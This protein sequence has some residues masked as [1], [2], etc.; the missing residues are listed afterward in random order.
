[1]LANIAVPWWPLAHLPNTD[2]KTQGSDTGL[3]FR[4]RECRRGE[5]RRALFVLVAP[6][7]CLLGSLNTLDERMEVVTNLGRS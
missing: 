3:A 5:E 6:F 4:E 7:T 1:M 2:R